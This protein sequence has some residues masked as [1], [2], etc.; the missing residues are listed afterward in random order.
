MECQLRRCVRGITPKEEREKVISK[1]CVKLRIDNNL[2][3]FA[4][5]M[6]EFIQR[7]ELDKI[8]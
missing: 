5:S 1:Y 8:F 4:E 2:G 6:G 7:Y 3:L